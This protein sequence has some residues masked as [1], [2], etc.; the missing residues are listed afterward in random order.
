MM[1]KKLY[2]KVQVF[3]TFNSNKIILEMSVLSLN[4][5]RYL[6]CHKLILSSVKKCKFAD[7]F[8]KDEKLNN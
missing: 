8:L 5:H 7:I 4:I 3:K 6:C 2:L 1:V